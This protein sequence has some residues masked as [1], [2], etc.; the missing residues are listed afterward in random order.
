MTDNLRDPM[1]GTAAPIRTRLSFE[2]TGGMRGA[3]DRCMKSGCA[4]RATAASCARPT[5]P[6][7]REEDSTRGR[8]NALVKTLSA[9]DPRK[10]LGDERLHEVLD[11]CLMCKACKSECPLGVDMAALK[12]ETLYH[13]HEQHG[14]P[15]RSRAFGA[16]RALNRLGSATAPLSNLPGRSRAVRRAMDRLLGITPARPLPSF[17][18]HNLVRWYGRREPGMRSA[19]QGQVTFLADSFTTFTEPD[20]GQAAIELL[21]RAGW[22]V[23]LERPAAAADG[24][25]CPRA[26]WTRPRTTPASSPAHCTTTQ[27]RARRLSA[28]SPR[29]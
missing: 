26:C 17:A 12:A 19:P 28:A 23:R 10:A 9:P 1:L 16:I 24:P 15:L 5:W 6:R 29:A 25:A 14:V 18:R 27:T 11:L 20:I 7:E 22:R 13:Y 8:A 4:A 2:V 3:A 21:E